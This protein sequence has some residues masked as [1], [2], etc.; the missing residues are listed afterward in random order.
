M[1]YKWQ[2]EFEKKLKNSIQNNLILR[3]IEISEQEFLKMAEVISFGLKRGYFEDD[4]ENL[5]LTRFLIELGYKEY[6]EKMFWDFVFKKLRLEKNSKYQTIM[7]ELMYKT[8]KKNKLSYINTGK[9]YVGSILI[10][11]YVPKN[12]L[13]KFYKFLES[14]YTKELSQNFDE[15]TVLNNIKELQ[16]Y[17]ESEEN[18]KNNVSTNQFHEFSDKPTTFYLLTIVKKSIYLN[19][20]SFSNYLYN[21]LEVFDSY[22][23]NQKNKKNLKFKEEQIFF[24]NW[25][26][27]EPNIRERNKIK[28]FEKQYKKPTIKL[29]NHNQLVIFIPR[30][31]VMVIDDYKYPIFFKLKHNEKELQKGRLNAFS[32][33]N[34]VIIEQEKIILNEFYQPLELIIESGGNELKKFKLL[35]EPFIIFDKNLEMEEIISLKDKEVYTI[36]NNKNLILKI[37]D[38]ETILTKGINNFI[39]SKDYKYEVISLE[40]SY[41]LGKPPLFKIL[42]NKEKI[43][44]LDN[45]EKISIYKTF[46]KIFIN[47]LVEE[48][49]IRIDI[50]NQKFKLSDLRDSIEKVFNG[51]NIDFKKNY[52]FTSGKVAIKIIELK[53]NKTIFKEEL[54]ILNFDVLF[55]KDRYIFDERAYL[56]INKYEDILI[57]HNYKEYNNQLEIPLNTSRIKLKIGNDIIYCELPILKWRFKNENSWKYNK[58]LSWHE[59]FKGEIEINMP[60]IKEMKL[61]FANIKIINSIK[62]KDTFIFNLD[63]FLDDFKL[64]NSNLVDLNLK[65]DNEKINI[66]QVIAKLFLKNMGIGYIQN[67]QNLLG[68]YEIYGK[69]EYFIDIVNEIGKK[70]RVLNKLIKE[71]INKEFFTKKYVLDYENYKIILGYY[72]GKTNQFF[73][74]KNRVEKILYEGKIQEIKSEKKIAD[75]LYNNHMIQIYSCSIDKKLYNI[76]SF[77]IKKIELIEKNKYQGQAFYY[78]KD[79]TT[80]Y[81]SFNNPFVFETDNLE[82]AE[83][84]I[85]TL[86]DKN[87]DF[88]IY[89]SYYKKLLTNEPTEDKHNYQ[90][91]LIPDKYKFK[92]VEGV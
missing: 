14:F 9:K 73:G 65:L 46:P 79:G 48:F 59:D 3:D 68:Q 72:E 89:D 62:N 80:R 52:H 69:G 8:L 74:S 21:Y 15:E 60:N 81:F 17:I 55:N 39:Y 33:F 13:E 45:N 64:I 34:K 75:R 51:F 12:Y 30:Q 86:V 56:K 87:E 16:N 47:T 54:Y 53:D 58:L 31:K 5:F 1:D 35:Q 26:F 10:N 84:I 78:L 36:Y 11:T 40:E 41:F 28:K 90:R 77:F 66:G 44:K 70:Q 20:Q 37:N 42:G 25:F 83:G 29:N 91:W 38:E 92:I 43:F 2:I 63:R 76:K 18:K 27:K 61:E 50:N 32:S 24:E 85:I 49:N 7:S 88:P 67:A 82:N 4:K 71:N 6:S 23:W 22:W 19:K 57:H